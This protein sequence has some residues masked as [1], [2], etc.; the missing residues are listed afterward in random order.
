MLELYQEEHPEFEFVFDTAGFGKSLDSALLEKIAS[1]GGQGDFGFIPDSGLAANIFSHKASKM[2]TT[3]VTNAYVKIETKDL[4]FSGLEPCMGHNKKFIKTSWGGSLETG[5]LNYGQTKH[6]VL[7][8]NRLNQE[9]KVEASLIYNNGDGTQ[10]TVND[11][12]DIVPLDDDYVELKLQEMRLKVVETIKT[13][14]QLMKYRDTDG[15][16]SL[17][18]SL[19]K[20]FKSSELVSHPYVQNLLFD[21]DGD[22]TNVG[23]IFQ[24]FNLTLEAQQAN[25]YGTWG[26]HYLLSI[27]GAHNTEFTNNW[28][29]KGVSNYETSKF[30]ETRDKVNEI[31][32]SLP[33]PTQTVTIQDQ[34]GNTTTTRTAAPR[35]NY[36]AYN[37]Q[38]GPCVK[39][40]CRVRMADGSLKQAQHVV[41]GDMVA[42]VG[43]SNVSKIVVKTKTICPE[44]I[45]KMV[46]LEGNDGDMYITPHHPVYVN[47]QWSFPVDLGLAQNMPCDAVYSFL[48]E[49][50]DSIIVEGIIFATF[51]HGL[52]G[53]VIGH[54]FYGTEKVVEDLKMLPGWNNGEV[55]ITGNLVKRDPNTNIVVGLKM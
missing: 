3:A 33:P 48:T 53:P 16:M 36:S 34:Y 40:T 13:G 18:I 20:E 55:V 23:Q 45:F 52:E 31:F 5:P 4:E 7:Q 17:F 8:V 21:L 15:I 49:S 47:S 38:S 51:A 14:F 35:V 27:M 39:G 46:H 1:K 12:I 37:V 50:R 32:D 41:A 11:T 44:N 19:I 26:K 54:P 2:M 43:K 29:D 30:V 22:E 10:T 25:Y 24:A 28:K 42:T 6:Y 9:P